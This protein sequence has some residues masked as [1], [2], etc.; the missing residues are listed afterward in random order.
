MKQFEGSFGQAILLIWEK[1][2]V[3]HRCM[4]KVANKILEDEQSR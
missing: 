2:T 4:S 3:S 1:S